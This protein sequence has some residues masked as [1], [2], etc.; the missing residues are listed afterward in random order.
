MSS[1]LRVLWRRVPLSTNGIASSMS[2]VTG[3]T[4][5]TNPKTSDTF[6]TISPNLIQS[7]EQKRESFDG[8]DK[9]GEAE[10]RAKI[11]DTNRPRPHEYLREIGKLLEV[12]NLRQGKYRTRSFLVLG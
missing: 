7:H 2:S 1:A 9:D 3:R 8:D 10:F 5:N 12:G 6:G 4:P 11:A